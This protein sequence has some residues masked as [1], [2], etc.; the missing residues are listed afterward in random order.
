MKERDRIASMGWELKKM[1]C[2]W[3]EKG[4]TF[5]ICWVTLHVHQLNFV[6]SAIRIFKKK[7]GT[8]Q[9]GTIPLTQGWNSERHLPPICLQTNFFFTNL[10]FFSLADNVMQQIKT[11]GLLKTDPF[12]GS[13]HVTHKKSWKFIRLT[14]LCH[15]SMLLNRVLCLKAFQPVWLRLKSPFMVAIRRP[16]KPSDTEISL[17]RVVHV[18]G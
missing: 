16:S 15:W 17:A 14:C 5:F 18:V 1:R 9:S 12:F 4:D 2:L 6:R 3:W 10:N 11:R 8:T 13:L 7:I